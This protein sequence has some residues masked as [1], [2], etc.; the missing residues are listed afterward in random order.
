MWGCLKTGGIQAYHDTKL[1]WLGAGGSGIKA[2]ES[3]G[4]TPR[5]PRVGD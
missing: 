4:L 1:V 5:L 2:L 3:S